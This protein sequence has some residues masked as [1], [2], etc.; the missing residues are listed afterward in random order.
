VAR[1]RKAN[2]STRRIKALFFGAPNAGKTRLLG[3]AALDERTAPIAIGDFDGGG[4]DT[5]EGLPGEGTDWV[6]IPLTDWPDD[7]NNFY[8]RVR[9]ND[10]GFRSIAVD[11]LSE[12]H[13]LMLMNCLNDGRPSREKEPDLIQE[14]DYGTAMVQLRRFTRYLKDLPV[15]VFYT[16]HQRDAIYPKEG[17]VIIPSM[18]G[19]AAV[20]IPG[21]MSVVGYLTMMENGNGDVERVMLLQNYA[22]IRTKVRTP[23]GV[24]APDEIVDPTMT[25]LFDTLHIK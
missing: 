22:K 9:D 5:L 24:E 21:L 14:G 6:R 2:G 8:E 1:P 23:W 19:K 7:F 3:T 20:E 15:H 11:S 18:A 12:V 4:E 13:I 16:S 25:K 10:E 17:S